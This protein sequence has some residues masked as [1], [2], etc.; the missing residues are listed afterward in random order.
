V[1]GVFFYLYAH[2]STLSL[3]LS[4]L[5]LF[6]FL[7]PTPNPLP[8]GKRALRFASPGSILHH[9][10]SMPLSPPFLIE[11]RMSIRWCSPRTFAVCISGFPAFAENDGRSQHAFVTLAEKRGSIPILPFT[12]RLFGAAC[13]K[14]EE[15]R[16]GSP[17]ATPP[18]EPLDLAPINNCNRRSRF[19][20]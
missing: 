5:L 1:D 9:F 13:F 12:C 16:W 10:Y 17:T 20:L 18:L 11:R 15:L 14:T 6:L 2:T 7:P 4:F 19:R 8:S 3:S